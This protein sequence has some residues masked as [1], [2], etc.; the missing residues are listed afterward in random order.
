M[1]TIPQ[2]FIDLAAELIGDEFAAFAVSTVINRYGSASYQSPAGSVSATST[3]GTIALEFTK[4]QFDGQLVKVGDY[5]LIGQYQL[6]SFEP[7]PDNC[8]T[9]RDGVTAE[10]K[11]VAVDPAKATII[12][13]VRPI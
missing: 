7:S 3:I 5:M 4:N 2:E 10:I 8:R 1:A 6:M 9:V 11:T 12:L 13:H